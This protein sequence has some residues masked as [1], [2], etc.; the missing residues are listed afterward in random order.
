MSY[1]SILTWKKDN[2]PLGEK[3]YMVPPQIGGPWAPEHAG[4]A[5]GQYIQRAKFDFEGSYFPQKHIAWG[6]LFGSP[7]MDDGIVNSRR[8]YTYAEPTVEYNAGAF[9]AV[10]ALADWFNVPAWEGNPESLE[11]VIPFSC[12]TTLKNE[13]SS[14]P[15][16][17][18][19]STPPASLP[20]SATSIPTPGTNDPSPSLSL[21]PST[22]PP[23][24]VIDSLPSNAG[25]ATTSGASET[26][27]F[28]VFAVMGLMACLL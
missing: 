23:P 10:A 2:E 4:N 20:N 26:T 1:N 14:V 24:T 6:T 17:Q 13:S 7:L 16:M 22:R 11:G 3:I 8:D 5:S 9:G 15:P 28:G 21:V 18:P 25:N 12:E 27:L 19:A